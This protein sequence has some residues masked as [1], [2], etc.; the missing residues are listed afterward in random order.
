MLRRFYRYL[1]SDGGSVPWGVLN[2]TLA[3]VGIV[4]A[5]LADGPV[6]VR[7]GLAVELVW[8]LGLLAVARRVRPRLLVTSGIGWL[9][10]MLVSSTAVPV[11]RGV[12]VGLAV[13]AGIAVVVSLST[14]SG[15]SL[16]WAP[17][18]VYDRDDGPK[19]RMETAV[20]VVTAVFGVVGIV[21]LV[22]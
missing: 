1:G 7:A 14:R 9:A 18:K 6:S 22:V 20:L 16:E 8:V 11:E 21:L 10:A 15:V 3:V 2:G 4:A 17:N 13:G 19:P 12:P 5:V